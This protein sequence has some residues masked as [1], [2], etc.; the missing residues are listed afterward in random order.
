MI[1]YKS[2]NDNIVIQE[3][4]LPKIIGLVYYL[5]VGKVIDSSD[6]RFKIND[7]IFYSKP[8]VQRVLKGISVIKSYRVLGFYE[9]N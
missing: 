5:G 1:K 8:L 3:K 9:G 4:E 6:K 2:V 7:Y